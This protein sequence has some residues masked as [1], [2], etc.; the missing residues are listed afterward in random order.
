MKDLSVDALS[1]FSVLVFQIVDL[2][3]CGVIKEEDAKLM[4]FGANLLG[5][6]DSSLPPLEPDA[7]RQRWT[8]CSDNTLDMYDHSIQVHG[9]CIM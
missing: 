9:H 4:I 8:V 7:L 1:I 5:N 2:T 3:S 6:I